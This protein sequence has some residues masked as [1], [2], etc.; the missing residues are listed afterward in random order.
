MK[1]T[2]QKQPKFILEEIDDFDARRGYKKCDIANIPI[3]VGG[4]SYH[5]TAD[6]WRDPKGDI[7]VRFASCGYRFSFVAHL[8]HRKTIPDEI[9]EDLNEF[10]TELVLLWH[11]EGIDD[12]PTT[13][14][15]HLA[16]SGMK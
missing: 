9:L 3:Y 1:K 2:K 6:F 8:K 14:L 5:A 7:V 10:V 15:D 11:A 12:V 4:Y 13:D 16:Y